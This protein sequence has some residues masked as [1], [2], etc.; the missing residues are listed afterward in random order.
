MNID[1]DLICDNINN[2]QKDKVYED[3]NRKVEKLC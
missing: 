3:N 2:N 1:Q